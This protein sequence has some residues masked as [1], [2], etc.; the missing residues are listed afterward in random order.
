MLSSFSSRKTAN[1]AIMGVEAVLRRHCLENEHGAFRWH[2]DNSQAFPAKVIYTLRLVHSVSLMGFKIPRKNAISLILRDVGDDTV[3]ASWRVA[4]KHD[5][6]RSTIGETEVAVREHLADSGL[7][8]LF[9]YS[10]SNFADTHLVEAASQSDLSQVPV[11]R[12]ESYFN[13]VDLQTSV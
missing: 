1:E 9:T 10:D 13:G 2:E 8:I 7:K 3:L 5:I 12:G 11:S 4:L 6:C